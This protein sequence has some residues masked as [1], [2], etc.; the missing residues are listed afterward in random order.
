MDS[1]KMVKRLRYAF[2]YSNQAFPSHRR[3][4]TLFAINPQLNA[5]KIPYDDY[6]DKEIITSILI[7]DKCSWVL[8]E[9]WHGDGKAWYQQN[10]PCTYWQITGFIES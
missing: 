3:N 6:A 7:R 4:S 2:I 9:S 5:G 1:I 10:D 8:V